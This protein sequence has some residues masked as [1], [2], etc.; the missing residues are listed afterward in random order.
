[1]LIGFLSRNDTN[2]G[3]VFHLVDW[4]SHK[5][6]HVSHS[7]YAVVIPAAASSDERGYYY[8]SSV[9]TLFPEY[10]MKQELNVDSRALWDKKITL[11]EGK[12]YRLR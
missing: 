10:R 9:N 11:H 8:K 2:D 12:E 7:A 3:G 6:Q 5:Q 4:C 1:M